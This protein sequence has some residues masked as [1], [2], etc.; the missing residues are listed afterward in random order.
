ML[1]DYDNFHHELSAA[2]KTFNILQIP[3]VLDQNPEENPDHRTFTFYMKQEDTKNAVNLGVSMILENKSHLIVEC[4]RKNGEKGFK[5]PA[6][7]DEKIR[8]LILKGSQQMTSTEKGKSM[9]FRFI[10]LDILTEET[11][12]KIKSAQKTFSAFINA[13]TLRIL[14]ENEKSGFNLFSKFR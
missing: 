14:E 12:E 11:K 4:T 5:V 2:I 1:L 6:S 8:K 7:I 13:A 3:I 9:K 10:P